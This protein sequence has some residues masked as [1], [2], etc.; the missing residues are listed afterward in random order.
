[1]GMGGLLQLARVTFHAPSYDAHDRWAPGSLIS[2]SR[3]CQRYNP[4]VAAARVDGG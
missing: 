2:W 1:M 3:T 4:E